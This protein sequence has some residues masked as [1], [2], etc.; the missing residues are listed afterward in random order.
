MG[1]TSCGSDL[2]R[3]T[4]CYECGPFEGGCDEDSRRATVTDRPRGSIRADYS[5]FC[6]CAEW[7]HLSSATA[8]G[9][10]VEAREKGWRWTTNRGWM[11]LRCQKET[12][13][14]GNLP[15]KL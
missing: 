1:C 11:C 6:G 8:R 7:E 3:T 14:G 2:S 12:Q 10:R 13:R 15:D 5:V 4:P 9:R